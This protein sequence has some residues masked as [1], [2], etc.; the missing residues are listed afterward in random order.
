MIRKK[1][2]NRI[3]AAVLAALLLLTCG[4]AGRYDPQKGGRYGEKAM[5]QIE[6]Y[7]DSPSEFPFSFK[8]GKTRYSGFGEGFEKI[9]GEKTKAD[10]GTL[11]DVRFLHTESGV[12]FDVKAKSYDDY[13]AWEW[14]VYMTNGTEKATKVFS[15]V[16][17]ADAVFKG[18]RP[19]L[20][21]I[22]GDLGD[23]YA[24]YEIDLTKTPVVRS[25]TS[26]RPTHGVFPYFNLDY[27]TG[28]LFIAV[29]WPGCWRASFDATEGKGT[30]FTAGQNEFAA[31]LEPGET[32]RTPL[33]AFLRHEGRDE[34]ESMN[35]WR[36]WFI[37]CNMRKDSKGNVISPVLGWG[38]VVQ[39]YSTHALT[40]TYNAFLRHDIRLD[41]FW[42]DAGWYVNAEGSSCGWPET[43]M[44]QVDTAKFPDRLAEVS[45]LVHENGGKTL[46]WFEPEVVRCSP[47]KYLAANPDFKEEWFLGM[48]APGSWLEGQLVDLGNPEL[49]EWLF[50]KITTVMDEGG[51][52]MYRQDFNV[53]PAE[54]WGWC[55]QYNRKGITE[56]KYV[57]GYL[58]LW[59]SL[60]EK[61]P[62]MTIDSCASGG[63]RND[64]ETMRRA[65]PLHISDYWDGQSGRY[66]ER[67]A[68][69]MS[70][71]QWFPYFKLQ[72]CGTDEINE[73]NLRSCM[74][75]WNNMNVPTMSK[76]TPWDKVKKAVD[77]WRKLSELFYKDFYPLTEYSS[78]DDVWR[79]YEYYD[80]EAGKGAV[81]VFR[82]ENNSEPEKTLKLRADPGA[83]YTVTDCDGRLAGLF[84]GY[85]LSLKGIRITLEEPASSALIFI[86]KVDQNG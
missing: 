7:L 61:Y 25:S 16:N 32:V 11:Y 9:S 80:E 10:D 21:G 66:N 75:P 35:L 68:V 59:D 44:W 55:D 85:D 67:Q 58:E 49:R 60:L 19:V 39:S 82:A 12:F 24:P 65:V 5:K 50:K 40:R 53:D 23:M 78:G 29:G 52:D 42:M 48:A 17:A 20:K 8:Y 54:V 18:S 62:D 41:Y 64:L 63:G 30:R 79:A 86:Q 28:G 45:G 77:E 47:K 56:N 4:C 70:L 81:M 14:T 1:L 51:I 34:T 43:G 57:C 73:Y 33:V 6:K 31:S 84:S 2:I 15:E 69:L 71:P 38:S 46:L 13:D 83:T 27:G 74:A 36:R 26:G 76:S 37:E 72:I 22:N 3:S